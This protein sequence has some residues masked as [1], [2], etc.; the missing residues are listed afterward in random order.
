MIIKA[1]FL[2]GSEI[3]QSFKEAIRVA[4]I[5]GCNIEF[6]FNGVKCIAYPGGSAKNGEAAYLGSLHSDAKY[7]TAHSYPC[8]QQ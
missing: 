4:G 6:M 2:A 5:L 8:V 7:K 1:E 3:Q